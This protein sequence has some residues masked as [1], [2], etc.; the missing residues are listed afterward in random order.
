[1][2]R[3]LPHT[4]PGFSDKDAEAATSRLEVLLEVAWA[5]LGLEDS[6]RANHARRTLR[7]MTSNAIGLLTRPVAS[8]ITWDSLL[9]A[10]D[11]R[12]ESASKHAG[13][14]ILA[15]QF[16][17]VMRCV[18][19]LA[20]ADR[21]SVEVVFGYLFARPAPPPGESGRLGVTKG[22]LP[23]VIG[24]ALVDTSDAPIA[25]MR[26]LIEGSRDSRSHRDYDSKRAGAFAEELGLKSGL[27]KSLSQE[28]AALLSEEHAARK[29]ARKILPTQDMDAHGVNL[30]KLL[31][32]GFPNM[33][34]A[35]SLRVP[36]QRKLTEDRFIGADRALVSRLL[37]QGWDVV[38]QAAEYG[39]RDAAIRPVDIVEQVC[40]PGSPT[41]HQ[42][43]AEELEQVNETSLL[44][45]TGRA[46]VIGSTRYWTATQTVDDKQVCLVV[47]NNSTS[48]THQVFR[49]GH[50]GEK[51]RQAHIFSVIELAL[52]H[53]PLFGRPAD[54]EQRERPGALHAQIAAIQPMRLGGR[55][56]PVQRMAIV[57]M[58]TAYAL[59]LRSRR[60]HSS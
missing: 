41:I 9:K 25:A 17:R 47:R 37:R 40:G 33:L 19:A 16:Q 35:T 13:N 48:A 7:V 42:F 49:V 53:H 22:Q 8:P 50:L 15:T 32:N 51:D 45:K 14:G 6:P 44:V 28:V 46:V 29:E 56:L 24:L 36:Q 58:D 27:P 23:G 11:T 57:I 26:E 18:L 5:G 59:L 60:E 31:P 43:T 10:S 55:R 34:V 4:S 21:A 30:E 52:R 12:R 2:S 20:V 54:D 39:S 38:L 3:S 1:M